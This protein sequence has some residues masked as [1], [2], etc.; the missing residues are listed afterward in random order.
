MDKTEEENFAEVKNVQE[1]LKYLTILSTHH[2]IGGVVMTLGYLL[3]APRI[4]VHG[5]L[6]EVADDI[7][8]S[9]VLLM[10]WWPFNG[11]ILL[12]QVFQMLSLL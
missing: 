7:H 8:D 6:I 12:N 3:N 5:V 10:S 4:F 9:L 1:E 2:L 11:K